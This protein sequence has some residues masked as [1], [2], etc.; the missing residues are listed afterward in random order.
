MNQNLM[1][2]VRHLCDCLVDFSVRFEAP[3]ELWQYYLP[4]HQWSMESLFQREVKLRNE[5]SYDTVDLLC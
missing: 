4:F 3:T 1:Y 2:C 5:A